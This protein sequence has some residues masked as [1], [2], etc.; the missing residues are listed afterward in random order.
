MT[1][2]FLENVIAHDEFREFLP[3]P[4]RKVLARWCLGLTQV[5]PNTNCATVNKFGKDGKLW[6]M[7]KFLVFPGDANK[8]RKREF[9]FCARV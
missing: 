3:L 9:L 7:H 4:V 1:V 5:L 6:T 2:L 8:Y